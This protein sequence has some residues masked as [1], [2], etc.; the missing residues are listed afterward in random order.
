[1]NEQLLVMMMVSVVAISA[2]SKY[3][4][5]QNNTVNYLMRTTR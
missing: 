3:I 4:K 5:T 2:S 1:M